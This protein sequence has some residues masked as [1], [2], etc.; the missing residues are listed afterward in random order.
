MILT[1]IF[2]CGDIGGPAWVGWA[3]ERNE[4]EELVFGWKEDKTKL[5]IWYSSEG[6]INRQ[7]FLRH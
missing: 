7:G 3:Y 2:P 6:D 5:T 1:G 4:S